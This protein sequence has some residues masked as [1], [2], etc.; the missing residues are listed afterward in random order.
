MFGQDTSSL[1][2]LESCLDQHGC[3]VFGPVFSVLE[4]VEPSKSQN[5]L[6]LFLPNRDGFNLF[7]C[8]CFRCAHCVFFP[9]GRDH[10]FLCSFPSFPPPNSPPREKIQ[11]VPLPGVL[12]QSAPGA[13][14]TGTPGAAKKKGRKDRF[15]WSVFFGSA[16]YFCVGNRLWWVLKKSN[17]THRSQNTILG[18]SLF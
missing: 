7:F 5:E 11:G 10:F 2:F 13:A 8:F 16:G 12:S 9:V 17:K 18:G 15:A 4:K 1:P 14:E 6:N 3:H